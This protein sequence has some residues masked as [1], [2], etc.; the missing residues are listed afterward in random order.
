MGKDAV[1]DRRDGRRSARLIAAAAGAVVL[2]LNGCGSAASNHATATTTTAP[3]T[4][5]AALPAGLAAAPDHIVVVI[6]ENHA[7]HAIVGNAE[8]PYINS[9]VHDGAQMTRSFATTHPSQPNYLELY[10]G[11]TQGVAGDGCPPQGSPNPPPTWAWAW[12]PPGHGSPG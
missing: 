3:P 2:V 11:S 5:V 6:E 8:A 1:R 9:L 7:A 10:S 12:A 4:S